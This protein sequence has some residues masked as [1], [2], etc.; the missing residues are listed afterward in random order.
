MESDR[1]HCPFIAIHNFQHV[2]ENH[3]KGIGLGACVVN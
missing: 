2:G 1:L 3:G